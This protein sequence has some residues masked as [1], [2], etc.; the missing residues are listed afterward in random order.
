MGTKRSPWLMLLLAAVVSPA[1]AQSGH[2]NGWKVSVWSSPVSKHGMYDVTVRVRDEAKRPVDDAQVHL[3][4]SSVG[5]EGQ[6]F[7]TLR[8]AGD[9]LYRTWVRL[10][11]PADNPRRLN[12][13][14]T[15]GEGSE[16]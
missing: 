12:V 7:V 9:G 8:P 3:R 11:P 10:N 2:P 6:R 1:G 15:P 5:N 13:R 14:V 4:L 16:R